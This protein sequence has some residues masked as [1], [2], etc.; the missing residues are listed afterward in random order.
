MHYHNPDAPK[1]FPRIT[2]TLMLRNF[3]PALPQTPCSEIFS[4]HYHNPD[5]PKF[6]RVPKIQK[7]APSRGR[8]GVFSRPDAGR[9]KAG[10]TPL[11][12]S[13]AHNGMMRV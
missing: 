11:S 4:P 8:F 3:F 13:G 6:F 1:S 9:A 2:A 5:A 7:S 10:E 12:V